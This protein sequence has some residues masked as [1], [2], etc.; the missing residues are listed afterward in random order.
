MRHKTTYRLISLISL[1][2]CVNLA[3]GQMQGDTCL[4]K[5]EVQAGRVYVQYLENVKRQS[6]IKVALL[7]LKT[8]EQSRLI[9][10]LTDQNI[11]L[12]SALTSQKRRAKYITWA[13][14]VLGVVIGMTVVI[15]HN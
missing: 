11:N 7:R 3:F 5:T 14:G 2:F 12:S 4:T 9:G 10:V 8:N 6:D 15:C 1:T 13:V